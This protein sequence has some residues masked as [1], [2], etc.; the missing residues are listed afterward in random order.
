M[1]KKIKE[2]VDPLLGSDLET[3]N[4]ITS[5]AKRLLISKHTQTL[6]VSAFVNKYIPT[7]TI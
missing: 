7:K 6:L 2:R 1:S 4:E 5:A 3:H